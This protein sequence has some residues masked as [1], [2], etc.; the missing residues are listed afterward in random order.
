MELPP[1]AALYPR[2]AQTSATSRRKAE[3]M[4]QGQTA[5]GMVSRGELSY[6]AALG[7]ENI[8]APYFR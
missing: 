8:S 1:L 6:L 7:S 2:K 3:V 5:S 4:Q